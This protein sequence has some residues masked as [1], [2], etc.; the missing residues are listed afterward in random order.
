MILDDNGDHLPLGL[1]LLLAGTGRSVTV[2]SRQFFAGSQILATAD[3]PWLYPQLREAGV[4]LVS[5][6][7]AQGVEADRVTVESMW[8][9][10]EREL[11]ADTVVL[12]M[13]RRPEDSLYTALRAEGIAPTRIGDCLSPREVDDAMYEG[14]LHGSDIDA[15]LGDPARWDLTR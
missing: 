12:S 7:V 1:A 14:A 3:L 15:S 2:A 6:V 8:G 9:G 5:Q 11:E 10:D 4:E 13:M